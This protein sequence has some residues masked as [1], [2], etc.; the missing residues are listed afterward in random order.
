MIWQMIT[1]Y[2]RSKNM[3]KLFTFSLLLIIGF[4]K[5]GW[6]RQKHT[7]LAFLVTLGIME[8]IN[9]CNKLRKGNKTFIQ[10]LLMCSCSL[11]FNYYQQNVQYRAAFRRVESYVII[12]LLMTPVAYC[13]YVLHHWRLLELEQCGCK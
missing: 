1:M 13:I 8:T 11:K 6:K 9:W 12:L 3:N 10:T 7:V 5:I 2:L 4:T